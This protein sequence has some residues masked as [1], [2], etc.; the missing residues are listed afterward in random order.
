MARCGLKLTLA[1]LALFVLFF[2]LLPA[3]VHA[4]IGS[5]GGTV[6]LKSDIEL[7]SGIPVHG[8]GH[9]TWIVT[10]A[11]ARELRGSIIL[12]YDIPQGQE[13]ANGQLE[14][15][16]V[17][18]YA[19]DLEQYLENSELTYMGANLRRFALLNRNVRDDTRGLIGTSNAS[20]E[21]IELRFYYDAFMPS[22]E[23][24]VTLSDTSILD[25]IF[26]PLDETYIAPGTYKIEH[27]EYMVSTGDFSNIEID[28]GTFYLIRTPFGDIFHYSASFRADANPNEKLLY[29]PFSW[30]ECPLILFIVVVVFGYFVVT[31]PG[32]F[33]RYDVVKIVKVHTFAKALLLI[34][35]LL[36]L[37]AGIGSIFIQGIYIWIISVVFLFISL[38]I[39]KTVYENAERITRMPEKPD[40]SE[41][42]LYEEAEEEDYEEEQADLRRDVQC[43]TCGEIFK[44]DDRFR[45]SSAPCPACG[46]IGAVE[47]GIIEED[48]PP[49]SPPPPKPEKTLESSLD[50]DEE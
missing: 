1:F 11:C 32:K 8:G 30:I 33:R 43:A 48:I 42:K 24:K 41:S 2:S 38:V 26:V 22:G 9:F 36:Y 16:E 34:L 40:T 5:N 3:P 21:D 18:R 35:I 23:A 44:M 17:N 46:S 20:T 6:T 19:L 4:D 14:F 29:E 7:M 47:M 31:M 12:N 25:A 39:S 15:T 28:K 10:G 27:T 50:A 13:P 45:T 37:F 49:P